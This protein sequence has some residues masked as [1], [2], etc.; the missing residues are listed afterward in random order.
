MA[1]SNRRNVFRRFISGLG[2]FL[3]GIRSTITNREVRAAYFWIALALT[4]GTLL[5][6][7]AGLALTLHFIPLAEDAHLSVSIGV[8]LLRSVA[9]IVVLLLA[10]IV[11]ITLC[12]VAAPIFSEIPFLA[13][14]RA[15][16]PQ[17]AE[18]LQSQAGLPLASAIWLSLRRMLLFL[19]VVGVCLMIGLIPVVGA[20]IA[21]PLQLYFAARTMGWEM[22]DPYFDKRGLGLQAQQELVRRH[23]P[24]ILGMGAVCAPLLAVPLIGPL[25]FGVLQASAAQFVVEHLEREH[26]SLANLNASHLESVA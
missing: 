22:L 19:G 10:P 9:L 16:A 2:S 4:L 26:S 5:L 14:M 13:G 12:N 8:W 6:Q 21:T 24:E 11:A 3:G 20:F 17:L 7:C 25:A 1:G 18:E 23:L 15:I